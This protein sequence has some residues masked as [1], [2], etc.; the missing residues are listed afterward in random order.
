MGKQ[1]SVPRPGGL[2]GRVMQHDTDPQLYYPAWARPERAGEHNQL[3]EYLQVIRRHLFSIALLAIAGVTA[4]ACLTLLTRPKYR[5]RTTLDIQQFDENILNMRDTAEPSAAPA[6]PAE[7]Y[8]QTEIKILQSD[9]MSRRAILKLK[10]AP[11]PA[12]SASR[13]SDL[14]AWSER[15]GKQP[16]APV[17]RQAALVE[18]S[19]NLKVRTLGTTRIVEVLCDASDPRLA[20]AFCNTLAAEYIQQNSETRWQTTQ[21]TED[22]LS[23]Q[24]GETKARLEHDEEELQKAAK[25]PGALIFSESEN[26]AQDKLRQLQSELSSAEADRVKRQSMY[27]EAHSSP[28]ES[29]PVFSEGPAREYEVKLT[30]LRRQLA[31]LSTTLTPAHYKMQQVEAQIKVLQASLDAERSATVGRLWNDYQAAVRRETLLNNEYKDLLSQ[32]SDEAPAAVQYNILKSEVESGRQ[33]YQAMLHRVEELG[34]ASAM[35][36]ST[37]RVVDGATPPLKPFAPNWK[38]NCAGGLLGGLFLGIALAFLRSRSD[39]SLQEP[40]DA[41]ELLHVRELGVIPSAAIQPHKA[42]LRVRGI[43]E[44]PCR[45]L[46]L[47]TLYERNSALAESFSAAM[48][49]ILFTSE[50]GH[51]AKL[52]VVTSPEPGDGKT[53]VSSNLAIALAQIDRKVLLVDGDLRRRRLTELLGAGEAPGLIGLLKGAGSPEEIQ[54]ASI[55]NG[56]RLPKLHFMPAGNPALFEP[57]L[58][59]SER[60]QRFLQKVRDEFDIVLIDSVPMAHIADARVVGRM[61]DGVLLVFRSNRT[62]VELATAAQRCLMEDGTRV[63]GTILNGW[64]SSHSSRFP[65]YGRYAAAYQGAGGPK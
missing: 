14:A 56:W 22:W 29:L 46:E 43:T 6:A 5:A 10:A 31:E 39:R 33:L 49:S 4:G 21:Q 13:S 40:G 64:N 16:S 41:P 18:I 3:L 34:I 58:L 12:E 37:I 38:S 61:S 54:L 42:F 59:H 48:N 19:R 47:A 2:P 28:G 60:M 23:K 53:T 50:G 51:Q 30:D 44:T 17:D 32:A 9:Q 45:T 1:L 65:H 20:A 35:R 7:S 36:A 55:D 24:L 63:I 27:E 62:T 11:A 26:M 8:I 57:K 15:V 25:Q 52:I